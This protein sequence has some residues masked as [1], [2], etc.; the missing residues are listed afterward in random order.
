MIRSRASKTSGIQ[1]TSQIGG[2]IGQ[3]TENLISQQFFKHIIT[4]FLVKSGM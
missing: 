4:H 2:G 3:N 1:N